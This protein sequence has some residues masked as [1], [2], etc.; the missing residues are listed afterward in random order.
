MG[1]HVSTYE[2]RLQ[3]LGNIQTA[4]KRRTVAGMGYPNQTSC[5]SRLCFFHFERTATSPLIHSFESNALILAN[6]PDILDTGV[7]DTTKMSYPEHLL[8]LAAPLPAALTKSNVTSAT[9]FYVTHRMHFE[10]TK[11]LANI[12]NRVGLYFKIAFRTSVRTSS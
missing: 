8:Q 3:R 6:L 7:V 5:L 1:A 10:D 4:L 12:K 9:K 11:P 2:Y